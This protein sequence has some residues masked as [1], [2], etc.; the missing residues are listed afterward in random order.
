MEMVQCQPMDLGVVAN[1]QMD[2]TESR[3]ELGPVR[4]DLQIW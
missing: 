2:A 4:S 1:P 3:A